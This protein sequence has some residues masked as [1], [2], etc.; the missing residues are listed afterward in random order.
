L[1]ANWILQIVRNDGEKV[2]TLLDWGC[3]NLD[4]LRKIRRK[5]ESARI[6]LIG[7]DK[8]AKNN[9]AS[10][11]P[12]I[13]FLEQITEPDST[14]AQCDYLSAIHLLE[15]TANPQEEIALMHSMLKKNGKI[16]IQV[17]NLEL[18]PFDLYVAD[19]LYHFTPDSLSFM[20][21]SRG[22]EI[23]S[24]DARISS[25]EISVMAIKKNNDSNVDIRLKPKSKKNIGISNTVFK[26]NWTSVLTSM[27]SK[28]VV[29]I[30]GVG[31]AG[32]WLYRLCRELQIKI[33]YFIDDN[34]QLSKYS[35]DNIEIIS[36][37]SLTTLAK[38]DMVIIPF[39]MEI[40]KQ[41]SEHLKQFGIISIFPNSSF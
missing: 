9:I 16:F 4:L 24:L 30:Y 23:V 38:I 15:H 6:Q 21:E 5:S 22:F 8:Y 17:P 11:F 20:L 35:F 3:G 37:K 12:D 39:E 10:Q 26:S 40:A 1:I 41:K 36:G 31:V 33:H 34:E 18:N 14:S 19:H 29:A 7:Y 28:R 2:A 13:Q 27:D 32:S 25:K